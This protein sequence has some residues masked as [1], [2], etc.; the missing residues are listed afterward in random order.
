MKD[1]IPGKP[2]RVELRYDDGTKVQ[3][4]MTRADEPVEEGT[5]LCKATLLPDYVCDTLNIDRETSTPGDALLAV[6]GVLGKALLKI[7]AMHWD[8]SGYANLQI[9]GLT[10]IAADR[11]Y[12]DDTG[13][14]A[15]Y[16]N[17]GTYTVGSADNGKFF[18]T[19]M[20]PV[21]VTVAAGETKN[22][23]LTEHKVSE[24]DILIIDTS[25]TSR[26]SHY[27]T[28]VDVCLIGGGGNG[29]VGGSGGGGYYVDSSNYC[30]AGG[31][32]GG[33]AGGGSAASIT[34]QANISIEQNVD[35]RL[36][37]GN[38]GG[39]NTSGFS[40]TATGGKNGSDGQKGGDGGLPGGTGGTCGSGGIGGVAKGGSGG[41]GGAGGAYGSSSYGNTGYNGTSGSKGVEIVR[42]IFN[43]EKTITITSGS[44]GC[45][46]GGGGGG[47]Y[48]PD[49]SASRTGQ[50]GYSPNAN[51]GGAG[52]EGGKTSSGNGG[53]G[54]AGG[55]SSDVTVS[56]GAGGGGGSFGRASGGS[57]GSGNAIGTAG[58]YGSGGNG[59]SGGGGGG[60]SS[61]ATKYGT[62]HVENNGG[63]SVGNNSGRQ[64]V[65]YIKVHY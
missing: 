64:G 42:T 27:V 34:E 59:R 14:L 56:G 8:G 6:P 54:G 55:S 23:A 36:V 65:I 12:T 18:D 32:G 38:A 46:G 53:N 50:S 13:M 22:V 49:T 21:S 25:K 5:P 48:Y 43:G 33:G 30:G 37:V 4:T 60:G 31:G 3:V 41:T 28:S 39:G 51:N 47:A 15:V 16:V 45:G 35:Y 11:C 9:T 58:L 40:L 10:G 57:G 20:P 7:K 63:S 1:R 17:E 2:G 62:D 61:D 19:A 44:G 52:G 26:F 24:N 29:G